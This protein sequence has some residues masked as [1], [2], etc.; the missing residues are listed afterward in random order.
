MNLET[1]TDIQSLCK[2]W[3][4]SGLNLIRAK[5]LLRRRKGVYES[6]SSRRTSRK[7]S[8]HTIPWSVAK[9]VKNYLGI[10]VHL[11]TIDPRRKV[12]RKERY[13]ESRKGRL[14]CCCNQAWMKSSGR[15]LWNAN[16]TCEMFKTPGRWENTV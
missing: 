6:F 12:L 15:I 16:A 13:A 5:Q 4:F 14:R 1:I 9:L 7:S 8:T 10:I 11:H 2:I 3:P